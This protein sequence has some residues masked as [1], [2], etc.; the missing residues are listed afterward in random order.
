MLY[1]TDIHNH[2]NKNA[3][4]EKSAQPA[5]KQSTGDCWKNLIERYSENNVYNTELYKQINISELV[6]LNRLMSDRRK[7]G[8]ERYNTVLQPFNGR[9]CVRDLIEEQLDSLA[10]SE[11]V[12]LEFPEL[13]ELMLNWQK[14]TIDNMS[15]LISFKESLS[16]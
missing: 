12:S 2:D 14:I 3:E 7:L 6:S 9:D 1:T 13:K 15:K 4:K 10:Y 11:Q 16:K 5:P 8:I